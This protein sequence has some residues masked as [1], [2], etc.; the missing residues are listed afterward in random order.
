MA[1]AL[2][3]RAVLTRHHHNKD[4][5]WRQPV[6]HLGVVQLLLL[7]KKQSQLISMALLY[8]PRQHL[9]TRTRPCRP[10]AS[11]VP[12]IKTHQQKARTNHHWHYPTWVRPWKG[13]K[14]ALSFSSLASWAFFSQDA[15]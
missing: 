2:P 11:R 12:Q 13:K 3:H 4:R 14:Q 1:E 9:G 7:P 10:R 15:G 8:E 6:T 5:P